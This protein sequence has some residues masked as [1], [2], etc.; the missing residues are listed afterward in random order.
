M[1]CEHLNQFGRDVYHPIALPSFGGNFNSIPDRTADP[2]GTTGQ[3]QVFDV[4][5]GSL[6]EP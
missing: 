5:P 3:V 2:D 6:T 1:L 4:K